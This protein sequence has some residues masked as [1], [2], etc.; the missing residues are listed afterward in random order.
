MKMIKV[1]SLV[2]SLQKHG[3]PVGAIIEVPEAN[4]DGLIKKGFA[5]HIRGPQNTPDETETKSEGVK[6]D[7]LKLSQ[8]KLRKLA[9]ERG[10]EGFST[11]GKEELIELLGGE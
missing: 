9:K 5:E 10:I 1:R 8:N 6:Q 3:N 2:P 11:K 4:V 7:L